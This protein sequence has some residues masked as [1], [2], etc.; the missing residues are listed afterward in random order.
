[1]TLLFKKQY[2]QQIIAGTKTATRRAKRPMVKKGG[3]YH[4]RLNFFNYLPDRIRVDR[5]YT[6]SLGE[7]THDDVT[8]EGHSSLQDYQEEWAEIYGFWDDKQ[9]VWVV[10][11][12][13]IGPEPKSLNNGPVPKGMGYRPKGVGPTRTHSEL[14]S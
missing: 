14:G 6:Q 5:L 9:L 7:M 11:F 12:Q 4:I 8:M 2:I 1:M 13:Y 3:V 10:E